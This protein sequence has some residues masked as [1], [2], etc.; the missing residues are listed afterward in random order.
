MEEIL[1]SIDKFYCCKDIVYDILPPK[2]LQL[3]FTL[4]LR[5]YKCGGVRMVTGILEHKTSSS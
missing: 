1:R 3:Y 2:I 4:D 5:K